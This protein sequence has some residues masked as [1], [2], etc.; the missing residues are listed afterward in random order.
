MILRKGLFIFCLLTGV[1][2]CSGDEQTEEPVEE[3]GSAKADGGG[4]G[5]GDAAAA[6]QEAPPP[7][8]EPAPEPAPPPPPPPPA[9][10]A[11][12][13]GFEGQPTVRYVTKYALNVRTGPDKS[14][15]IK[16]HVKH[17]DKLDCVINGE[18]CKIGPQQYVSVKALSA[19]APKP[20][21]WNK[22]KAK[23]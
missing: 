14:F 15:P 1:A 18:W 12:A 6:P 7:E 2:A 21:K 16:R 23:K 22:P 20:L 17:G 11:E 3:G 10:A 5:E 8:P 4:E 9:Q 13:P 19:T